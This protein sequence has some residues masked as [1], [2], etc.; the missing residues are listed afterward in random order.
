MPARGNGS[1]ASCHGAYAPRYVNNTTYLDTPALEGVPPYI[2]PLDII[3]TDPVRAADQQRGGAASGATSFSAT[4]RPRARTRTAARRTRALRGNREL[5]YLAPPLYGVGRRRPTS[6]TARSERVGGAEARGS[7]HLAPRLQ[8]G[9]PDQAGPRDHGL[10]H[11]P[12][13]R[14]RPRAARLALRRHRL[15][16]RVAAQSDGL[17]L[18]QLRS[19]RRPGRIRSRSRSLSGL[20][21]NILLAWNI[22]F[23]PILTNDQME[24]RKNFNTRMFAQGNEGHEFN[25]VLTDAE[26]LAIVEYLKTL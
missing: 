13:S 17:A 1:C 11:R 12:R 24:D 15:R 26:R 7:A 22:L 19:R 3:G 2:T 5:G 6:T 4:P 21:T 25:A 16:A 10:R 9:P 23:P 8:G 14:L 20:Y 18:R